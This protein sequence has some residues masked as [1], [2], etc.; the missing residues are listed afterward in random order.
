MFHLK[1]SNMSPHNH[2]TPM[3]Q[4]YNKRKI[5]EGMYQESITEE[6]NYSRKQN[7][8]RLNLPIVLKP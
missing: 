8:F 5:S 2:Q 6:K 3:H 4:Y 1:M 7:T